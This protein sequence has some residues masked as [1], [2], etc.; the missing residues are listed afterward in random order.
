MSVDLLFIDSGGKEYRGKKIMI[1]AWITYFTMFPD[2]KIEISEIME[3]DS[4]IGL[5]GLVS[6]SF[7]ERKSAK[8]LI[9]AA[10]KVKVKEGQ[11]T[12]WQ[13]YCESNDI[14]EILKKN[15]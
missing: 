7:N 13:V 14:E 12:H 2:Y 11:V 5:F 6:G 1:Q 8:Y 3:T 4:M 10:W 15:I 9:P